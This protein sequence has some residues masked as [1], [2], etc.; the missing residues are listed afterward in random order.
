MQ[1]Q[2]IKFLK[3]HSEYAKFIGYNFNT[4][5]G[6]REAVADRFLYEQFIV[7]YEYEKTLESAQA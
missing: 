3:D 5:R 4:P 2:Y 1:D 7:E 6:I